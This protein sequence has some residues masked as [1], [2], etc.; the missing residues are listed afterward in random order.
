[1]DYKTKAVKHLEA[2]A[3]IHWT[4]EVPDNAVHV[5]RFELHERKWDFVPD[6]DIALLE[7]ISTHP[8]V[9]NIHVYRAFEKEP[10]IDLI[11]YAVVDHIQMMAEVY[12]KHIIRK[13]KE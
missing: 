3:E 2:Y 8:D 7:Y 5:L 1:M 10:L 12:I 11:R 13:H 9:L 4:E 6:S